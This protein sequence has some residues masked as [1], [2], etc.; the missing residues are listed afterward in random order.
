MTTR[1]T[2]VG[3]PAATPTIPDE[4]TFSVSHKWG[5]FTFADLSLAQRIQIRR[6]AR[7]LWGGPIPDDE[8]SME[9]QL[10]F[11]LAELEI[12][13]ILKP[14]AVAWANLREEDVEALAELWRLYSEKAA[15]FRAGVATNP[16]PAG[17]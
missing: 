3:R 5:D 7:E 14:E 4:Y 12:A 10:A 16:A 6:R 11:M 13:C 1:T 9:S 17:A 15:T 8:R 2:P